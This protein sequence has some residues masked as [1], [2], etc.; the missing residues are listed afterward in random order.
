VFGRADDPDLKEVI[1]D[2]DEV[3][4]GLFGGPGH[5]GQVAAEAGRAAGPGVVGDLQSDL[6]VSTSADELATSRSGS[7][8][9]P[10]GHGRSAEKSRDRGR[11]WGSLS[12][13][14]VLT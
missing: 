4:A 12:D 2:A 8:S 7:A 13:T 10:A 3:E 9:P 11:T 14:F 6:H 5:R 1:H